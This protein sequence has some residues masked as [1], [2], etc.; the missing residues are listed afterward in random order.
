MDVEYKQVDLLIAVHDVISNVSD[1]D[2][3]ESDDDTDEEWEGESD[4]EKE[5]E[6]HID[7]INHVQDNLKALGLLHWLQEL[8][9][10][11]EAES[12]NI[13][14][15]IQAIE[16]FLTERY[17]DFTSILSEKDEDYDYDEYPQNRRFQ[18]L[19]IEERI[20][21]Q[22]EMKSQYFNHQMIVIQYHQIMYLK[23]DLNLFENVYYQE[24]TDILLLMILFVDSY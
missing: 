12:S 6:P 15:T 3:V 19:W 4:D 8:C 16:Q 5:L 22:K 18:C 1:D 14:G 7:H 2:T 10:I 20:N 9:E 11:K 24:R 13:I 17:Q 21:Q 23:L